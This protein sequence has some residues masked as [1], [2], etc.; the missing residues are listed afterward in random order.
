MLYSEFSQALTR[1]T[2]NLL[3]RGLLLD[4]LQVSLLHHLGVSPVQ[5]ADNNN[6]WPLQVYPRTLAVL[7]QVTNSYC[8][9]L[10]QIKTVITRII[11]IINK[12]ST[13]LENLENSG[14]SSLKC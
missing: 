14:N 10:S 5:L 8:G 11:Q 13:R 12:M 1:Y 9:S 4:T 2:H 3:A 6:A 7:A